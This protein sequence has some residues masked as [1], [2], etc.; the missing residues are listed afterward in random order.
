MHAS[1]LRQR[2][3][4]IERARASSD[5]RLQEKAVGRTI[6]ES[7]QRSRQNT[8]TVDPIEVAEHDAIDRWIASPINRYAG[9]ALHQLADLVSRE[10]FTSAFIDRNGLVLW[11]A[12]S[13]SVAR[14]AEQSGFLLGSNWSEDAVGTNGPG[15]AVA[16]GNP[17]TVFANEH[18]SSQ[19]HDWVCY[20]APVRNRFGSIIGALDIST[21][22]RS[23]SGLALATV[24]AMS[25]LV[26][27]ALWN[28]PLS[29]TSIH[30]TATGHQ[31]CS[32]YGE[33]ARLSLRQ[34]EILLIL[35]IQGEATLSELH[36]RLHGERRV[37]PNT[38]KSEVSGLRRLLGT[39]AISSR[40]YRIEVEVDV[41]VAD[42]LGAI[43]S[44]DLET[45]SRR[46]QGQLLPQSES[47][48]IVE[49]RHHIDVS[50]RSA[51]LRA[52]SKDQLLAFQ[53][54]HP[55]DTALLEAAEARQ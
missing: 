47:P 33:P 3:S 50:F 41:D 26:E 20:A 44:G 12:G 1:P 2:R 34:T 25:S 16:S 46:Y 22:W 40:P 15:T 5:P 45:A 9:S 36:D 13:P 37:S 18:W 38:T 24:T 17:V 35:A 8:A 52:G 48:A 55:F 42:L 49:L 53:R 43:A 21:S 7:W 27:R 29:N 54:F 4:D 14:S 6:A 30:L 51:L 11:C 10:N 32:I 19:V 39:R 23:E 31:Q 28:A